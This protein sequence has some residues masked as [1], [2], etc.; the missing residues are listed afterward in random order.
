MFLQIFQLAH[1]LVIFGI[2]DDRIVQYVVAVVVKVDLFPEFFDFNFRLR[3]VHVNL[4]IWP[5]RARGL[6]EEFKIFIA[7]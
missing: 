7:L 1:E 4:L 6:R 5:Q 2:G 3:F